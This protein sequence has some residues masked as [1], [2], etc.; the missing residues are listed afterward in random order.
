LEPLTEAANLTVRPSPARGWVRGLALAVASAGAVLS[1]GFMLQWPIATQAWPVPVT[2]LTYAFLGAY[3]LGFAAALAWIAAT[4][5]VAGLQGI[6]LTC[7]VAFGSMSVVLVGMAGDRPE[8]VTDLL[9]V[10]GLCA[11][12][13]GTLAFGLRQRVHDGRLTPGPV[14]VACLIVCGL[15]LVLGVPLILRVADVMPWSLDLD[16]G[17][18]IGCM[19]VGSASYFLYGALRAEWPHAAGPLAALLAYDLVLTIPLIGHVPTARPEHLT[20]LVAYIAVLVST[21]LLGG[22]L[23]LVDR[24]TRV[25]TTSPP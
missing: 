11:G 24:R 10:I 16:S 15:L 13:I 25:G 2:P 22:Y 6:G 18:L 9:V 23:F 3:V 17:A 21:A 5:E 14:R 19:F 7:A 1:V 4:G 20:V 8:L 12:G